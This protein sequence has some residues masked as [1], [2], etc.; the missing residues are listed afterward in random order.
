MSHDVFRHSEQVRH[1]LHLL[2][3]STE[4]IVII[5]LNDKA[6]FDKYIGKL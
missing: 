4:K 2:K 1:G 6:Q 3:F 5:H